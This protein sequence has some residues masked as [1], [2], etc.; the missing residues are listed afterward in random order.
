ML[1]FG[2]AKKIMS[3]PQKV[4]QLAV[5]TKM[6]FRA[7]VETIN[8]T[9]LTSR[10]KAYHF[11]SVGQN[12]RLF[13]L[14]INKTILKISLTNPKKLRRYSLLFEHTKIQDKT[15]Y[16]LFIFYTALWMTC[17]QQQYTA[18]FY[19]GMWCIVYLLL[20]TDQFMMACCQKYG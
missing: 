12:L 19:N 1:K 10:Q 5:S 9:S 11:T 14:I 20:C 18:I 2:H 6:C 15:L 7:V 16:T 4:T 8:D 3:A 17:Y 13:F